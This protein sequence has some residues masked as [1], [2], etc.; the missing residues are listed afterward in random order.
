[1]GGKRGLPAAYITSLENRL[2]DTEAALYSALRALQ[3][4]SGDTPSIQLHADDMSKAFS[5]AQCSKADKQNDW[6]RHPLQTSEDLLAWFRDA[7]QSDGNVR[8]AGR[9]PT[10]TSERSSGIQM[11]I[12]SPITYLIPHPQERTPSIRPQPIHTNGGASLEKLRDCQA[13]TAPNVSGS[14]ATSTVWLD[15][16]F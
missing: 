6:T 10:V 1:V 14:A 13:P 5:R 12:E 7:S 2:R 3:D 15:N 16:Y 4:L 11:A 9:D 8:D